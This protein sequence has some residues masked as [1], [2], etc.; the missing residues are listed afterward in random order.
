M[1]VDA[2]GYRFK[3]ATIWTQGA[4]RVLA[5]TRFLPATWYRCR[6]TLIDEGEGSVTLKFE[7]IERV[8]PID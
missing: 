6:V 7:V 4:S 8:Q 3:F 2:N 5:L 1:N